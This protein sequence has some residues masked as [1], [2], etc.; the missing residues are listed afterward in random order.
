MKQR[1]ERAFISTICA[2]IAIAGFGFL[3]SGCANM[4]GYSVSSYQGPLPMEDYQWLE[5]GAPYHKPSVP[6][7]SVPDS[8][9]RK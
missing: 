7:A 4:T 2:V 6:A 9:V 1:G 8:S 5:M 3:S